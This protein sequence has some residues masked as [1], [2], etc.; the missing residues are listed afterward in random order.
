MFAIDKAWIKGILKYLRFSIFVNFPIQS[1]AVID[2]I[3]EATAKNLFDT[4]FETIKFLYKQCS[5]TDEPELRK[6]MGQIKDEFGGID[7]I[8]NSAGILDETKPKSTI[9]INYVCVF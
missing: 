6:C 9:D 5:V 1:L 3:D 2:L 8:V 7:I 4:E